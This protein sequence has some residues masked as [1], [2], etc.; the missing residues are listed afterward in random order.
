MTKDGSFVPWSEFKKEAFEL[1]GDYNGRWLQAEYHQ[2]VA[3]ANMAEKWK[4]YERDV[5]LY[6]N[7]KLVSVGDAR[8]RPEH[9]VLNGTIR[10]FNDPFWDSNTPPLDWGCRCDLEQ[11]DEEE[12][13]IKGGLQTKI[14]FE[15]N[16]GKTGK[17]FGGSAYEENLTK[18]EKKEA[19]KN[20]KQWTSE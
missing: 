8:V 9:K 15:N 14:E 18:V 2:T 17:I 16:P 13:E 12:T 7:L 1:S 20:L 10:P 5:D 19:K 6:P 3:N 4:D 11:T